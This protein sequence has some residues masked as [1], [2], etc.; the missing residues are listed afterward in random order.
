MTQS[1]HKV[2]VSVT[3]EATKTEFV[4][5]ALGATAT[6]HAEIFIEIRLIQRVVVVALVKIID[7]AVG[8][9]H[10]QGP[11]NLTGTTVLLDETAEIETI[12][13]KDRL[14]KT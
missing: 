5:V 9:H 12:N 10:V 13:L 11:L 2:N 8:I 3:Q 4:A 14:I 1:R 7:V 6:G